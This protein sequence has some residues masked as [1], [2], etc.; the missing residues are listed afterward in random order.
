MRA[1][2]PVPEPDAR[3][4]F[5]VR[6]GSFRRGV[7]LVP[8]AAN[9][10]LWSGHRGGVRW[11][12]AFTDERAMASFA[13]RLERTPWRERS[14]YLALSGARLLDVVVPAAPEPTGV[15]VDVAGP[16]PLL[17]PPLRGIVPDAAAVD[18]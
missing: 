16:V 4:A 12:Y 8:T 7:A 5:A 11:I 14:T 1:G 13:A 17:L 9:G 2:E 3:R 6:L 10:D 15:V 18:G